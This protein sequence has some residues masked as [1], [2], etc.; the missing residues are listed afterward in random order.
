M[1]AMELHLA[2]VVLQLPMLAVAVELLTLHTLTAQVA[3]AVVVM[4]H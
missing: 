3:L 2:L 1:V 4:G